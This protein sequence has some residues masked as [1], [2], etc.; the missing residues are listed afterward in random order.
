M[1]EKNAYEFSRI[2]S[3]GWNAAKKRLADGH[4]PDARENA[5]AVQNP[6]NTTEE[7]LRWSQGFEQALSSHARPFNTPAVRAWRAVKQKRDF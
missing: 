1:L 7:R 2:F 5:A 3:Q 6:Y 4:L